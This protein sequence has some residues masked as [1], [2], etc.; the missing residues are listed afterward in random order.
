VV[1]L[2]LAL[3]VVGFTHFE[4][5]RTKKVLDHDE[6]ISVLGATGHDVTFETARIAFSNK[7]VPVSEWQRYLR[8][9]N[10]FD[11]A[12]VERGV[13]STD[14]A[15]PLYYWILHV[16]LSALGT[17][18]TTA[19]LLNI[20]F[21]VLTAL[22]ITAL[23]RRA[24][25]SFVLG[26]AAAL[27]WAL[28]PQAWQLS[29][30]GRQ[31][32]LLALCSVVLVWQML[33]FLDEG[34]SPI[35]DTV[36]LG[37]AIAAGMLTQYY[38]ALTVVSVVMV[39]GFAA[40]RRYARYL[41]WRLLLAVGLAVVLFFALN[42]DFVQAFRNMHDRL[43]GAPTVAAFWQRVSLVTWTFIPGGTNTVK[44]WAVS[45]GRMAPFLRARGIA[46][47]VCLVILAVLAFAYTRRNRLRP[48][49][50]DAGATLFVGL[51]TSGVTLLLYLGFV[52]PPWAMGTRYMAAA[53]ALGAPA[54]VIILD[55]FPRRAVPWVVSVWLGL[56]LWASLVPILGLIATPH[57]TLGN[58]SGV[59]HVVI[60][61]NRRGFVLRYL[62]EL[63]STAQVYVGNEP[64]LAANPAPWLPQLQP[65]DLYVRIPG[66]SGPNPVPLR[67]VMAGRFALEPIPGSSVYRLVPA[68]AAT[69]STAP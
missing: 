7:W 25:G 17:A 15:P 60:D 51:W 33:R 44:A 4:L 5:A 58:L 20:P 65:G 68:G 53:W 31:Y 35:W 11:F 26:A 34:A 42:P 50:F 30:M 9:E 23:V 24:T 36:L 69:P 52:S 67:D 63:P 37:L 39:V 43:P 14:V 12:S 48:F 8:V 22:A 66:A 54:T 56:M 21:A 64:D 6:S 46:V 45:I 32:D 47:M 18:T 10:P 57:P 49:S 16:W 59:K 55:A 61:T 27:G 1:L 2:V 40:R 28:T 19:M 62:L 41:V 29:S 13:A 38:F 3:C